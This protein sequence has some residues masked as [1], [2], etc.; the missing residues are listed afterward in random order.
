MTQEGLFEI[1]LLIQFYLG[2]FTSYNFQICA[3]LPKQ[4]SADRLISGCQVIQ[5]QKLLKIILFYEH[6]VKFAKGAVAIASSF[7]I[8]HV[9]TLLFFLVC[10]VEERPWWPIQSPT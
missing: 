1:D 3:H 6:V 8:A 2:S 4:E 9:R 7:Y 10:Y 5:S